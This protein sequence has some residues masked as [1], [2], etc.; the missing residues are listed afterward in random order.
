MRTRRTN[1][2]ARGWFTTATVFNAQQIDDL[3]APATASVEPLDAVAAKAEAFARATGANIRP[4]DISLGSELGAYSPSQD[5]IRI[6]PR[7]SFTHS[8]EYYSVLFHELA[9]WTGHD[10]RLS[11]SLAEGFDDKEAYARE[12]L[13]AEM[14]AFTLATTFG[15]GF[16]PRRSA[17]YLEHWGD[18]LG[19][20]R[21]YAQAATEAS[22]IVRF[23]C[24]LADPDGALLPRKAAPAAVASD[25]GGSHDN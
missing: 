16:E 13:R 2:N 10:S 18:G 25:A 23:L 8:A 24:E 6:R 17:Q 7:A 19:D 3:P 14:A 11:R 12:E 5:R 15:L 9:H 22:A 1:P 20:P 4:T 21:I